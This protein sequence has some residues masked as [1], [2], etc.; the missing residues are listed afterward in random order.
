MKNTISPHIHSHDDHDDHAHA[1]H[2]TSLRDELACHFPY[3]AFSVAIG[4]V[5]LSFMYFW[6]LSISDPHR[7]RKGYHVL[8]HSFHYLHL[9]FATTGTFV[10]FSRFS[11]NIVRGIIVSLIS[12]AI[13][14]TLSDIALPALAANLLGVSM[15][16]HICFF[17][18]CDTL[19][20]LP[21]MIIGIISGLALRR[22]H[23]ASLGFFSLGSHFVHILI[24]SL[25][26]L[27]YIVSFGFDRWHH[28]MGFLFFFLVIA[29]VI[30]CTISDIVIPMYFARLKK[31]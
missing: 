3:A 9:V 12:P 24:S 17:E 26:A 14:C 22:H 1:S 23:E 6:G 2:E 8:F 7:L 21:F 25:A 16:V 29:V 15:D 19:N 11:N 30:P 4:F 27:F 13:F 31:K 18:W 5:V 20:I 10:T 28:S